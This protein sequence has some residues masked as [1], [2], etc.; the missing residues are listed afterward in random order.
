MLYS[1]NT[2]PNLFFDSERNIFIYF[3]FENGFVDLETH[4]NNVEKSL[5]EIIELGF[6]LNDDFLLQILKRTVNIIITNGG[7]IKS[8]FFHK[9]NEELLMI[10]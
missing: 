8:D 1:L 2:S 6:K 4:K 3:C 10:I 9:L 7:D 5:D